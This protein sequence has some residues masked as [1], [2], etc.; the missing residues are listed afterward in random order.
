MNVVRPP[1][2]A[3]TLGPAPS[4]TGA[5]DIRSIVPPQPYFVSAA[6]GFWIAL[7]VVLL[8]VA[9]VLLWLVLRQSRTAPKVAL[10]PRQLA[11]QQLQELEAQIDTLDARTFGGAVADVLRV[12]VGTQYRLH[13]ERQTSQEFLASIRSSR[14]FSPVEHALLTEFLESCDLLK[15]ARADAT[16]EGKRRLLGQTRD[17]LEDSAEPPPPLPLEQSLTLGA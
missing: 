17:F 7:A 6:A 10:T 8:G 5:P 12:Y 3:A 2:L 13:P 15:F 11:M 4:P 14:V 9:A 16:L 1:L